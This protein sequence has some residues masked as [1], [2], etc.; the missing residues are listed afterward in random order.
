[1][2]LR[3]RSPQD[4]VGLGH[5]RSRL[6]RVEDRSRDR[7][8]GPDD[9]RRKR[10]GS[11]IAVG[12]GAVWVANTLDATVSRIEPSTGTVSGTVPVGQGPRDVAVGLGSVWVANEFAGTV[13]Q[14]DP[15]T[16][17]EQYELNQEV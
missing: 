3:P 4:W 11:A 5:E 15:R 8:R 7:H 1:M 12:L 13:S 9:Q 14:I 10:A 17:S 2:G 16:N 6:E